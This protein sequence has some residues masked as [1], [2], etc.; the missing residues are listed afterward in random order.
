MKL[1]PLACSLVVAVTFVSSCCSCGKKE[2]SG[3]PAAK[4]NPAP[5]PG[6]PLPTTDAEWKARLTPEQYRVLR[7]SDTERP[8]TGKYDKTFEDGVYR[9]AGCGEVLFRSTDKFDSGCGWPA[10]SSASGEAAVVTLVDDSL[11]MHRV[12][13][14]CAKCGGHLGHVFDDGPGPTKKRF[15]INSASLEFEGAK[16]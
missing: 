10:F 1:V 12:E 11:G 3:P 16:K 5:S 15:C 4:T 7:E 8:F 14:R 13:V 9:C 6:K 2:N